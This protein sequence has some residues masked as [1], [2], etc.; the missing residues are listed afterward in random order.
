MVGQARQFYKSF[1]LAYRRQAPL[2]HRNIMA[3]KPDIACGLPVVYRGLFPFVNQ[4]NY[5]P[6][7]FPVK[8][9]QLSIRGTTASQYGRFINPPG[10][11]I[12]S[13]PPVFYIYQY[14]H[15]ALLLKTENAG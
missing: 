9:E 14:R 15:P 7:S 6:E 4:G 12:I 11:H 3:F 1:H 8:H 5:D 13:E 10:K 2:R